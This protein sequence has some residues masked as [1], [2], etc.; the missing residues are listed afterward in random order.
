MN[1][2]FHIELIHHSIAIVESFYHARKIEL[3]G[4]YS[5]LL[6]AI[7]ACYCLLREWNPTGVEVG[8]AAL[9]F[10]RFYADSKHSDYLI[11]C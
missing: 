4:E 7:E 10:T 2:T 5:L 1:K 3:V 11:N 6:C 8:K 9:R